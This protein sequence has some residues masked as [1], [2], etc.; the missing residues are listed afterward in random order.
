VLVAG[1]GYLGDGTP[2]ALWG[3]DAVV[4]SPAGIAQWIRSRAEGAAA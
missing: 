2:P 1:F 3:A 4:E